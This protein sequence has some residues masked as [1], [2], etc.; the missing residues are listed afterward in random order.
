MSDRSPMLSFRG[1]TRRYRGSE[2]AAVKDVDLDLFR[3]EILALIGESGSGKTTLLRLAAGLESPDGGEI[4]IDGQRVAGG[5][6]GR[7]VPPESRQL[8]LVFQDGALFPHL[9]VAGNAAYGLS[10]GNKPARAHRVA[11]CLDLVGLAGKEK[12]YPHE[13]SGG[14]RQRLALARAI[15]P[16]PKL[17]LL[18]EPFS[19]LDPALRRK[20]REEIREILRRVGQTALLVTHDPEDAL[21]IASRVAILDSGTLQQTGTPSEVYRTPSNRY[22]A[23]R[24]GPANRVVEHESQ[25]IT[26]TRPEDA[27]WIHC[28]V[29]N[30]GD[31]VTISEIREMGAIYEVRV[32]PDRQPGETWLCFLKEAELLKSGDRGRVAWRGTP[33]RVAWKS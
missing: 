14:E 3:G 17:L 22:C 32:S 26:W 4:F 30:E 33:D 5:M 6:T 2:V 7:E 25:S 28:D 11:E 15:A 8:G 18:D 23:E 27:R 20:L 13:L 31:L 9:T 12:R 21:A 10:K 16:E 24:F 19:H 1:I 29:A